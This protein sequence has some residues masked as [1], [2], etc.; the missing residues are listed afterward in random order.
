M[1]RKLVNAPPYVYNYT[2]RT[3]LNLKTKNE[4]PK[5]FYKK[6]HNELTNNMLLEIYYILDIN[7]T[8]KVL[9]MYVYVK[10]SVKYCIYVYYMEVKS[11]LPYWII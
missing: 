6:I 8:V 5:S 10:N 7:D 9:S 3:D 2:L 11:H 1:L 4:E